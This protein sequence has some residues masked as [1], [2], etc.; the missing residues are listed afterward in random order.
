MEQ[1]AAIGLLVMFGT[2]E[3]FGLK[4]VMIAHMWQ[5][6]LRL[7][8]NKGQLL[9]EVQHIKARQLSVDH[10]KYDPKK[11]IFTLAA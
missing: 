7:E 8:A 1:E 2:C 6:I 4:D 5:Q 11:C 10:I 3:R 9:V